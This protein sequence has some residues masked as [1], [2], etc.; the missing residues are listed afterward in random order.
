MWVY[1]IYVNATTVLTT[2][3][4]E[5]TCDLKC[6]TSGGEYGIYYKNSSAGS[7]W[8]HVQDGG[9]V[10]SNTKTANIPM[11]DVTGTHYIRCWEKHGGVVAACP[12]DDSYG[13]SDDMSIEV[14]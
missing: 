1:N 14:I 6:W 4:I 13:D 8:Q 11:D 3:T 7:T 12:E 10:T 9:C 2:D 5:V